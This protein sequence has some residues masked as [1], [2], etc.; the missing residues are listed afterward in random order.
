MPSTT[1]SAP[2]SSSTSPGC[3]D[4]RAEVAELRETAALLAETTATPPPAS[5]RESVLAGISQVRPLPPEVPVATPTLDAPAGRRA[6]MPFL[7]AAAVA[8]LV[9]VGAMIV[10]P[11]ADDDPAAAP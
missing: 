4:C 5:L 11:W 9:G 7:V 3:E 10:Q 8:L 6:W 1:S 2:A